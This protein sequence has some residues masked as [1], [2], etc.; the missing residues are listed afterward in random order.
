MKSSTPTCDERAGRLLRPFAPHGQSVS[1]TFASGQGAMRLL[2]GLL[3]TSLLSIGR[4]GSVDAAANSRVVPDIQV[5]SGGTI[6]YIEAFPDGARLLSVNSNQT[7]GI[8]QIN[9]GWEVQHLPVGTRSAFTGAISPD[10]TLVVTG[11]GD[12]NVIRWRVKDE[13]VLSSNFNPERGDIDRLVVRVVFSQDG[14]YFATVSQGHF[15]KVWDAATGEMVRKIAVSPGSWGVAFLPGSSLLLADVGSGEASAQDILTGREAYRLKLSDHRISELSVFG[16]DR[17]TFSSENAPVEVWSIKNK[18]RLWRTEANDSREIRFAYDRPRHLLVAWQWVKKSDI[19]V[20]SIDTG[21]VVRKIPTL[22]IA[23]A[24]CTSPTD[25]AVFVALDDRLVSYDIKSGILTREFTTPSVSAHGMAFSPEGDRLASGAASQLNVWRWKLGLLEKSVSIP[26]VGFVSGFKDN[27]TII[28]TSR[29][30]DWALNANSAWSVSL[31]DRVDPVQLWRSP[32]QFQWQG[33]KAQTNGTL[34]SMD[35]TRVLVSE[36]VIPINAPSRLRMLAGVSGKELWASP[37]R[38]ETWR[39]VS[40]SAD[41]RYVVTAAA[42]KPYSL[43]IWEVEQRQQPLWCMNATSHQLPFA[44]SS[45]SRILATRGPATDVQLLELRSGNVIGTLPM[46]RLPPADVPANSGVIESFAF[47]KNG[48]LLEA[49]TGEGYALVWQ[50]LSLGTPP[51]T[52]KMPVI[53][54][55]PAA[56]S[57]DDRYLAVNESDGVVE[58]WD[59][60]NLSHPEPVASYYAFDDGSWATVTPDG[61]YRASPQALR[62]VVFRFGDQAYPF[63]QFDLLLNRPDIVAQRLGAP[64]EVVEMY[65]RAHEDRLRLFG[66]S[67]KQLSTDFHLPTIAVSPQALPIS[68]N[69]E[70]VKLRI[71]AEDPEQ[72][73][74]QINVVVNG[75]PLYGLKGMRPQGLASQKLVRDVDVALSPGANRLQISALNESGSESRRFTANVNYSGHSE[76]LRQLYV[77][78]VGV[79]HYADS[80]FT[81]D[82]AAKDAEDIAKF[83]KGKEGVA[84]SKVHVAKLIDADAT[85]A[86][87]TAAKAFLSQGKIDDEVVVFV[88]GHGARDEKQNY[89]YAT[90]DMDFANPGDRG[91]SYE[92]IESLVDGLKARKRLILLDTCFAGEVLQ[93]LRNPISAATNSNSSSPATISD[94]AHLESDHF[95]PGVTARDVPRPRGKLIVLSPSSAVDP[96]FQIQSLFADIRGTSG[97]EVIA[98][99][100]GRQFA[101]EGVSGRRN[102]TFTAAV[103]EGLSGRAAQGEGKTVTASELLKYVTKRVTELSNGQQRPLARQT[104]LQFD[105]PLY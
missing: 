1:S 36:N 29:A 99:S 11:G 34:L 49:S 95:L 80:S 22:G 74:L 10:G 70:V 8:W 62:S 3:L 38:P 68:T 63:E 58:L 24:V 101:Y 32:G 4:T 21:S 12:G 79:S 69:S 37:W 61:Y 6:G 66:V 28:A 84:F 15:V 19:T 89:F 102:G 59:L 2:V 93:S 60:K 85:K 92:A 75:V 82:Y 23:S 7:V 20:Y 104:N 81:L 52:L 53:D 5:G 16:T 25:G 97:A 48:E 83:W 98:A 55:G 96:I 26:N 47:S 56:F 67:E 51:Q 31:L 41:H 64:D 100:G 88:S 39:E 13:A 30:V 90:Y 72:R 103:L 40:L 14:R 76:R 45:D 35:G 94:D 86:K 87:I 77:L 91:V 44:L 46:P 78:S 42:S 105:F 71:T 54:V 18:R 65:K 43:C 17:I 27:D 33:K 57:P 50:T 9:G 73:V